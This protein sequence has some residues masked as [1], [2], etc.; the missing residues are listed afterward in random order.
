MTATLRALS[1]SR[2]FTRQSLL[3]L[4]WVALAIYLLWITL[5]AVDLTAVWAR[6]QQLQPQQLLLLLAVNVVVLATFSARWWLLLYAQGYVVPYFTLMAYRLATFA[7]SY[8]TPGPHFGGEPLQVYLVSARQGVPVSVSVAA[9][10]LDKV[11]EMLANFAFL[12][13]GVVFVLRRQMLPD[14]GQEALLATS[15]FLLLL[16]ASLLGA[17]AL[18]R[19]PV[20]GLLRGLDVA[21]QRLAKARGRSLRSLVQTSVYTTIRQSEEQST[22]LCRAHPFIL[23]LALA[24]SAASWVAI[25]GEFWL[26]THVLGLD[27]GFPEAIT[28]LLAARVAILLPLPAALGALEASQAL[29]MRTLGL[30]AA[31]GISLSILIRARDV[32]LG[33][34]GLWIAAV[35][36]WWR[37][38]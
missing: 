23:L 8:F 12:A 24:A 25:I 2:F 32:L 37:K 20:S 15:L 33:L 31:D 26:M 13:L 17:L 16:P 34:V 4:F 7:V 1:R 38:K 10:V 3:R 22:L 27:L 36:L 5:R 35:T 30:P 9:V 14:W 21:G 18:G 11:L 28:A 6:L 19:H 29:A